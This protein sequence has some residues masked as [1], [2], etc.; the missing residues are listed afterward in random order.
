MD[1]PAR[2]GVAIFLIAVLLAGTRNHEIGGS[3][4]AGDIRGCTWKKT[5]PPPHHIASHRQAAHRGKRKTINY[6]DILSAVQEHSEF[7]F[8]EG[9]VKAG[10]GENKRVKK[11]EATVG[12]VSLPAVYLVTARDF[13]SDLLPRQ[14]RRKSLSLMRMWRRKRMKVVKSR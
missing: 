7:E 13:C 6:N 10:A 3:V 9:T 2:I 12:E 5:F 8:L 14:I 11:A 1:M 4:N